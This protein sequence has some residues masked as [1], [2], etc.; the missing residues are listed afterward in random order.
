MTGADFKIWALIGITYLTF[1]AIAG[2]IVHLFN[3]NQS[4]DDAGYASICFF[5]PIAFY[6]YFF[7]RGWNDNE[8][9]ATLFA[10][11]LLPAFGCT[12]TTF[13]VLASAK[14]WQSDDSKLKDEGLWT[15]IVIVGISAFFVG[16]YADK[17]LKEVASAEP[18]A[19]LIAS[20]G[21]Q[22]QPMS[23]LQ[24]ETDQLL[25]SSMNLQNQQYNAMLD[26]LEVLYAPANPRASSFSHH[27]IRQLESSIA[28]YEQQGMPGPIALQRAA[29]DLSGVY[30]VIPKYAEKPAPLPA[31][32]NA[33]DRTPT[34][35]NASP[36]N[37]ACRA[38]YDRTIRSIP[39]SASIGEAGNIASDAK[40]KRDRCLN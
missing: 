24:P 1:L 29:K 16:E 4:S 28:V 37:Q 11:P 2:V 14:S 18:A 40:R 38:S 32:E 6:A 39:D 17:T 12:I 23:V 3:K 21:T 19:K 22:P 13:F 36:H 10:S 26:Q 30:L 5:P 15:A 7:L 27:F 25:G 34:R 31:H 20:T 33:L 8:H 35:N 9:V